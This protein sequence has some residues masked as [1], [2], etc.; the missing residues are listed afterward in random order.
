LGEDGLVLGTYTL[1]DAFDTNL[2]NRAFY[3]TIADGMHDLGALVDGG[4]TDN[5][6]DYLANALRA[7]GLGQILG[8][9]KLT[10]QS[11]GQMVFLLTP[12]V[13]ESSSVA[14]TGLATLVAASL[15]RCRRW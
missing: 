11:G 1:F 12:V 14:L 10:S 13:P 9:G 8:S 3:F 6:W 4:L 7:N 5:G 15:V 2:G